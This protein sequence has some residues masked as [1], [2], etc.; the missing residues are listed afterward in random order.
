MDAIPIVLSIAALSFTLLSFW[1]LNARRG[2]MVVATP[3]TYAYGPRQDGFR[4][5]FPLALFND[6]AVALIVTHMRIAISEGEAQAWMTVRPTL[7]PGGEDDA[8]AFATPFAVKGRDA[9][10][11]IAEFGSGPAWRPNPDAKHMVR[12]EAQIHP[13]DTWTEIARFIWW[14]PPEPER[15]NHIVFRNAE[16]RSR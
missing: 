11:L 6:G 8:H 16:D 3:R 1:W 13:S 5:R 2:R 10:E 14:A 12:L 9:R 7:R 15:P 4:V